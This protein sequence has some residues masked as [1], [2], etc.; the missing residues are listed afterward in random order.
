MLWSVKIDISGKYI[1]KCLL[2][3][4]GE[5]NNIKVIVEDWIYLLERVGGNC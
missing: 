3:L 2:V 5:E 4:I 1:R